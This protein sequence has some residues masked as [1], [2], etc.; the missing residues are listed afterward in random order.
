[1]LEKDIDPPVLDLWPD[2]EG[3]LDW[4][5]DHR[6]DY[7]KDNEEA[8]KDAYTLKRLEERYGT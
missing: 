6:N 5:E 1:M 7:Y 8:A 4:L 3:Y 2:Y